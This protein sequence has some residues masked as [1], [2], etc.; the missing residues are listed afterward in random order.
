MGLGLKA[1]KVWS[2]WGR[3][4][5]LIWKHSRSV[6]RQ[7]SWSSAWQSGKSVSGRPIYAVEAGGPKRTRNYARKQLL[8]GLLAADGRRSWLQQ[9]LWFFKQKLEIKF[10]PSLA[11]VCRTGLLRAQKCCTSLCIHGDASPPVSDGPE[12]QRRTTSKR[13]AAK[14]CNYKYKHGAG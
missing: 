1:Q 10:K 8:R 11:R 6:E 12:T 7:K 2:S 9:G 14:K 3:A 13:H 5:A 4:N